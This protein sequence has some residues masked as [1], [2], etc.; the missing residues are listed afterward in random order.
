MLA[1][2]KEGGH[3]PC[4]QAYACKQACRATCVDAIRE[5]DVEWGDFWL[6]GYADW[7]ELGGKLYCDVGKAQKQCGLK[8]C[9]EQARGKCGE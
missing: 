9:V 7:Y 4:R 2:K 5:W 8:Q 1:A 6:Y 3:Y